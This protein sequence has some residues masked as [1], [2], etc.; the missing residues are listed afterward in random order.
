MLFKSRCGGTVDTR[1]LKSLAGDSVPVRV[2]SPAPQ[3]DTSFDTMHIEAG[4][5]FFAKALIY[6]GFPIP[7]NDNRLYGDPEMVTAEPLSFCPSAPFNEET[8]GRGRLKSLS[9]PIVPLRTLFETGQFTRIYLGIYDRRRITSAEPVG[10]A[11]NADYRNERKC[12][13]E[14]EKTLINAFFRA[15]LQYIQFT[16]FDRK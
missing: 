4:V 15:T 5:Q 2:R 12:R 11:G 9:R 16:F 10:A 1:D 3:L 13:P 14:H 7:F 6:K 8:I